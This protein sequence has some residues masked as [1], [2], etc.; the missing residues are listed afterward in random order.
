MS[1]RFVTVASYAH[2]PEAQMARNLLEAEGIP[3][4]LA[5][6]MTANALT[7]F[8]GE[9]HLQVHEQDA[10]RAVS[11]LAAVAARASLE[12]DWEA[13]AEQGL[14]T[15]PL[16]GTAVRLGEDVC[17]ACHSPNTAV[18]TD[19]R[20]TWAQAPRPDLERVKASDQVRANA[21]RPPRSLE[22][23]DSEAADP[24][25]K[26]GCFVGLVALVLGPLWLLCR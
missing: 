17:P 6:E 18:T 10:P 7:G 13:Q 25:A 21:P 23:E 15:W 11:L 4:F 24:K 16:C 5:G 1:D 14:W 9:A 22:N 8:A 20:D 12:P 3:A 2:T 26:A 19:R